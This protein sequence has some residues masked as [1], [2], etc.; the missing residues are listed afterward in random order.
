MSEIR[1]CPELVKI[2]ERRSEQSRAH[3]GLTWKSQACHG[4]HDQVETGV[5]DNGEVRINHC[6]ERPVV[7]QQVARVKVPVNDVVSDEFLTVDRAPECLDPLNEGSGA[8]VVVT[9]GRVEAVPLPAHGE[10][11]DQSHRPVNGIFRSSQAQSPGVEVE[12]PFHELVIEMLGGNSWHALLDDESNLVSIDH[13]L[14]RN[15][16]TRVG[17]EPLR[18]DDGLSSKLTTLGPGV[19]L[20]NDRL[21]IGSKDLVSP[22]LAAAQPPDE[23]IRLSSLV[24]EQ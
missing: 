17:P 10:R 11:R 20:H 1:L 12:E 7:D 3:A 13:R 14:G 23:L 5:T 18:Q 24:C 22:G 15:R 6:G 9:E 2:I 21:T 4:Q 8:T 19:P 16:P